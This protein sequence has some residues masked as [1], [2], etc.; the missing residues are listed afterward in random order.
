MTKEEW[1][2]LDALKDAQRAELESLRLA[3]LRTRYLH[4]EK[5]KSAAATG[6]FLVIA[7]IGAALLLH[8]SFW[9]QGFIIAAGSV[10]GLGLMVPVCSES[11]P[12]WIELR[13]TAETVAKEISTT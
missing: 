7:M 1:A 11:L 5:V 13:R 2:A 6:L 8:G 4:R 10:V 9:I 3:Y 12:D